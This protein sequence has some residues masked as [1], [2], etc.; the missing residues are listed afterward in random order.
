LA[1]EDLKEVSAELADVAAVEQA[2]M[3]EGRVMMMVLAPTKPV[4][5]KPTAGQATTAE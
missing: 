2:P 4:K 1:L 5:K 3:M